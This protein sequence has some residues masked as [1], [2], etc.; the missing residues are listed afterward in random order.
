MLV[1]EATRAFCY[2]QIDYLFLSIEIVVSIHY[3]SQPQQFHQPIPNKRLSKNSLSQKSLIV[4]IEIRT[5]V[6][7][8]GSPIL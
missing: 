8:I 2:L 7:I 6:P 5:Q 3:K 4:P 1:R